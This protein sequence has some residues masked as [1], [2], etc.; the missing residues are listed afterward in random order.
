MGKLLPM[1]LLI[2]AI[3]LSIVIFIGGDPPGS[4]LWN[5]ITNQQDWGDLSLMSLLT[6]ATALAAGTAI[7]IGTFVG[8]KSDF[9]VFAGIT[10]VFLS[11]GI[12][13]AELYNRFNSW[14]VLG[15]SH[16]YIALILTAPLLISYLY[17]IL[18][19]WRNS[20]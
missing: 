9:L 12:S 1:L 2:V 13:F 14:E 6:D 8:A 16:S 17:V 11:F 20:D 3:N 7:V 18:K 4:A 10:G 19:W 15:Q 5:L